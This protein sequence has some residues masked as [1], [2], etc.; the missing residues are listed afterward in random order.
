MLARLVSNSWP[1]DLASLAS[2]SARITDILILKLVNILPY[3]AKWIFFFFFETESHSVLP[4]LKCSGTISVHCNLPFLGCASASRVA[5]ITGV[6]YHAWLIFVFLVEM[7]FQHVGQAGL[8]LV[9]S[10]GLPS[11]ASQ[12]AWITSM[13]YRTRPTK[14]ILKVR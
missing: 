12:S 7:G 6:H 9:A 14:R 11:L 8:K 3:M 10:S 4:R 2:K 5:G 13:S 1:C